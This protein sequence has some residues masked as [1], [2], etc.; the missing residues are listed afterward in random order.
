MNEEYKPQDK[1]ILLIVSIVLYYVVKKSNYRHNFNI[2]V[3]DGYI[4]GGFIQY[5]G[6]FS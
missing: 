2:T 5:W 3:I 1:N 4:I 6:Y